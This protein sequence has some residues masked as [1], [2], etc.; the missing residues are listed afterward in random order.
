MFSL[1]IRLCGEFVGGIPKPQPCFLDELL[2]AYIENNRQVYK[3]YKGNRFYTWDSL[4]GEIE[5]FD[6][7]GI[8][9]GVMNANGEFIGEAIPGRKIAKPN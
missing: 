4:H 6:R 1:I 2:K 5:V 3:N 7:R 9:F 8:H